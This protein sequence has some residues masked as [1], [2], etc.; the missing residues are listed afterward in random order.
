MYRFES[1]VDSVTCLL[2]PIGGRPTSSPRTLPGLDRHPAHP[3]LS[4]DDGCCDGLEHVEMLIKDAP[5]PFARGKPKICLPGTHSNKT[6][7]LTLWQPKDFSR[8]LHMFSNS[9]PDKPTSQSRSTHQTS[10]TPRYRSNPSS[11]KIVLVNW[12]CLLYCV[13][14]TYCRPRGHDFPEQCKT[15][16]MAHPTYVNVLYPHV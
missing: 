8:W 2:D 3:V 6:Y 9:S 5:C 15:N 1:F 13:C 4:D 11:W 10:K 14:S 16:F 7:S 12:S